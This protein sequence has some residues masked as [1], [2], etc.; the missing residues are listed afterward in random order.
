MKVV[1]GEAQKQALLDLHSPNRY[2]RS[3]SSVL[4]AGN[5]TMRKIQAPLQG[6]WCQERTIDTRT[7]NADDGAH[8]LCGNARVCCALGHRGVSL[9]LEDRRGL[10]GEGDKQRAERSSG[11][12]PGEDYLGVGGEMRPEGPRW[13]VHTGH[14]LSHSLMQPI[15]RATTWQ[16]PCWVLTQRRVELPLQQ[17]E[18]RETDRSEEKK[19]KF[20]WMLVVRARQ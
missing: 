20:N 7:G 8:A 1:S 18:W 6:T 4:S 14:S 11:W 15:G 19:I 12:M 9:R 17:W 3:T 16:A 10:L 13:K 2:L 5:T